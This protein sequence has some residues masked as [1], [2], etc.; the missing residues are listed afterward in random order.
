MHSCVSFF[1]KTKGCNGPNYI[2]NA[3][4]LVVN[5]TDFCPFF[6]C[7]YAMSFAANYLKMLYVKRTPKLNKTI[8]VVSSAF[9]ATLTWHDMRTLQVVTQIIIV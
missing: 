6:C 9:K 7:R 1:L 8:H 4:H 2:K 3:R 5:L